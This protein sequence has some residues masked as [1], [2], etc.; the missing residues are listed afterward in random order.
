MNAVKRVLVG[1]AVFALTI[2]GSVVHTATESQALTYYPKWVT[3]YQG[4]LGVTIYRG[5]ALIIGPFKGNQYRAKIPCGL[6]YTPN[7]FVYG[8]WKKEGSGVISYN[9]CPWPWQTTAE[10]IIIQK[11][12][13]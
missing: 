8:G 4:F 1:A 2:I 7:G 13:R 11:R 9:S 10:G 5:H 12:T 6:P 3:T